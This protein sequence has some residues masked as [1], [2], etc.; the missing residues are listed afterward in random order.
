MPG[1][2]KGKN[3]LR[4][5]PWL[6]SLMLL[7]GIIEDLAGAFFPMSLSFVIDDYG[8]LTDEK[9]WLLGGLFFGSITLLILADWAFMLLSS[10]LAYEIKTAIRQD[11]FASLCQESSTAYHQHDEEFY[12]SLLTSDADLM[13][14][15]YYENLLWLAKRTL[16]FFVWAG[17]LFYVSWIMGLVSVGAAIV[18][19]LLSKGAG[20]KLEKNE[21]DVSDTD[22]SYLSKAAELL[23]GRDFVN[24]AT[25][26]KFEFLHNSSSQ[27]KEWKRLKAKRYQYVIWEIEGFALYLISAVTFASGLAAMR[28]SLLTAGAFATAMVFSD[29]IA[30]P[31]SDTIDFALKAKAGKAHEQKIHEQLASPR[32]TLSYSQKP[33]SSLDCQALSAKRGNFELQDVSFSLKQGEKLAILGKN[34]A[35]KS[36]FLHSALGLIPLESGTI[37]IDGKAATPAEFASRSAYIAQDIFLFDA[38]VKDNITLFDSYPFD[39]ALY[40]R[41]G[42]GKALDYPVG[43]GGA[44]LSGGEKAKLAILRALARGQSLL[45]LDEAFAPVDE[46][47]AQD[48][49]AFLAD[50]PLSVIAITHDLSP[51]SLSLYDQAIILKEGKEIAELSQGEIL[52][53]KALI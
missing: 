47:S 4:E 6:V 13:Y 5:H 38:S 51:K 1:K 46:K 26:K 32:T 20:R 48:I 12:E 42:L 14:D 23:R 33:I 39:P 29:M 27:R 43:K 10:K 7:V 22:A 45:L 15:D 41:I 44:N 30:S 19:L 8:S 2:T 25:L 52:K 21:K 36:T 28:S 50:S 40:E 16:N 53:A 9:C 34:G 49:T 35:G 11:V 17:C 18:C 24:E 31:T 37:V 3:Y